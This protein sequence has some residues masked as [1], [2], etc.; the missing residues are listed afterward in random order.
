MQWATGDE[1]PRVIDR[2]W[3]T[4][5]GRWTQI[6]LSELI[7]EWQPSFNFD[8][9]QIIKKHKQYRTVNTFHPINHLPPAIGSSTHCAS[10]LAILHIMV[11]K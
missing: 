9:F 3:L 7:D 6:Y 4:V 5:Y 8:Q 11:L 1:F 10:S 2:R